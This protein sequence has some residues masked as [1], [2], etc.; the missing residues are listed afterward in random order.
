MKKLILILIIIF[1][2]NNIVNAQC[3]NWVVSSL[4]EYED[5]TLHDPYVTQSM[6]WGGT[7]NT[8]AI[9]E[10]NYSLYLNI[11]DDVPANSM[12]YNRPIE[13]CIGES[14]RFSAYMNST[15]TSSMVQCNITMQLI[16]DNGTVV[17]S[18]SQILPYFPSWFHFETPIFVATS[19]LYHFQMITNVD[20]NPAGN[21]L[22]M[23]NFLM[24]RC[25]ETMPDTININTCSA[26]NL[27]DSIPND[28]D[29]TG[30]WTGPSTLDNG[31]L[32]FFDPVF[33]SSGQYVYTINHF[34]CPNSIAVVNVSSGSFNISLT[35]NNFCEGT[36]STLN[37]DN[38][39]ISYNWNTN[40]TTQSIIISTGGTYS[41]TVTD[42]NGCEAIESID[43]IEYPL[44]I[45]IITGNNFC[46]GQSTNL[47]TTQAYNSYEWNTTDTSQSIT[48]N[49][50]GTYSITVTDTNNC[51]A[52]T[53]INIIEY[54]LPIP[55]ITGDNFCE[56]LSTTINV[57]N[58]C[59]DYVWSTSDTSQSIFIDTE[60]IY[61]VTVTDTNN[62]KADTSINIIEY[63]K[64]HPTILGY[65][66][67]QGLPTTIDAGMG[68]IDYIWNTNDTTQSIIVDT[69]G[70]YIVTVT[71]IH[72]CKADTSVNVIEFPL[73]LPH[74]IGSNFC[75][76]TT[77]TLTTDT[78]YIQYDWSTNQTDSIITISIGG[79]YSVTITDHNGCTASVDT[80]I[81]MYP[82]PQPIITANT[83]ICEGEISIL[84]AGVFSQYIWSTN[85]TIQSIGVSNQDNYSV[86]VVD[87]NGCT[88][89]DDINIVVIPNPNPQIIGNLEICE[90]DNST[91]SISEQYSLYQWAPTGNTQSIN[92]NTAGTYSVTVTNDFGCTGTTSVDFIVNPNPVPVINGDLFICEGQTTVL[93]AG[94]YSLYIW[95][96]G[97]TNQTID[98]SN[99]GNYIVTVTD[100]NGCNGI[101]S[102]TVEVDI[103]EITTNGNQIICDGNNVNLSAINTLGIAP[104]SYYWDNGETTNTI[105]VSPNSQTNYS[106]Y[107]IDAMGCI[108]NTENITV[109]V[110]EGV[111]LN[112]YANKDTVCPG[113]P[114]LI[115]NNIS[116]GVPPYTL[117]DEFGNIV[118]N[119]NYI[120]YPDNTTELNYIVIDACNSTDSDNVIIYTYPIPPLSFTADILEGCPPLTVHFNQN[121]YNTDFNYVWT[122]DDIDENNLSLAYN[123]IHTFDYS[124]WYDITVQVTD[125]HGCKNQLTI[126]DMINVYPE[127]EAHFYVDTDVVS[128][129]D[130]TI[131]FNNY[132]I[133]NNI[134]VWGFGD[135]DSSL[136][137]NPAHKYQEIGYYYPSLVVINE[138]GCKDTAIKQIEVQDIFTLY[139]PTAFSPDY[140]NI[141]DGFRAVGHG[142]DL[143]NYNLSIYDRWG[144][145]IWTSDDLFEYWNGY[146]KGGEKRVQN[147]SYVWKVVCKDFKGNEHEKAGVVT[148][149]R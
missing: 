61:S 7:P 111:E 89:S 124:G 56:G 102:E 142:I 114:V 78:S 106:V 140:D 122:F 4:D 71:D 16:D 18:S 101:T 29:T 145:L 128:F 118:D 65:N 60:G 143:D 54:P 119:A 87:T 95:N 82:T 68:F 91:L 100:V 26:F 105:N 62:C 104:Y 74:I 133:D 112:T 40:D 6:V 66:F 48:I 51:K 144:E 88:G 132:S 94:N 135:G 13:A 23:D 31:Y 38:G 17:F 8:Y 84:D 1:A 30:T 28:F 47:T 24:E 79:Q 64:P 137:E 76:G 42:I 136:L 85:D 96:T 110:S 109:F 27:F 44:P 99:S 41:V 35:G 117:Y 59:V 107:V 86:I 93:D 115:S 126:L 141:N 2:V 139:V 9:Y 77:A 20:G 37:A 12:F 69:G 121:Q 43:I 34:P 19:T 70:Q 49:T 53:S 32:G 11:K 149:I 22:T 116:N 75:E 14:Y 108:S 80:T 131:Y 98:V 123:P 83:P 33:A 5:P 52:D 50:E 73:P 127:P 90:G 3:N 72:G 46:L 138:Y 21:D 67:C 57:E 130:A 125:K 103:V 25:Q 58:C 45:P 129:I 92:V 134:N 39:F 55:I 148:V 146:A 81:I 10:G 113:D 97:S 120:I 147:G 63:P 36:N 15:W